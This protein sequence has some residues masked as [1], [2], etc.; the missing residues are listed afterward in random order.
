MTLQ[1]SQA[2]EFGERTEPGRLADERASLESWLDYYRASLLHKCAGLTAPQLA[3]RSC[4]PS[5]MS[6]AGLVRHMTEMERVY[7]HRLADRSLG[8]LYCTEQSPEG[9]FADASEAT[10]P[11]SPASRR[12]ESLIGT[13]R[14]DAAGCQQNGG[15]MT[16]QAPYADAAA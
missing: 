1:G 2:S 4:E 13:A 10:A 16:A 14:A 15:V 5:A 7:A 8:E 3:V 6:L 12:H 11:A 9:D